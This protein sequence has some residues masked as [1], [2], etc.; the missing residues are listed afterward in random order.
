VLLNP[1]LIG[2]LPLAVTPLTV[3]VTVLVQ[4]YVELAT[5]ITGV[6]AAVPL[7]HKVWVNV[8]FVI[9]GIGFTVTTIVKVEPTQK[10]VDGPLGVT[11]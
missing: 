5:L 1:S 4:A 9:T 10:V 2:P 8:A 3:P 7:P 11:V 6:N